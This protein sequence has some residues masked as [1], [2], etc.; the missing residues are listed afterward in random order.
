MALFFIQILQWVAARGTDRL[1]VG[2]L[3]TCG[4]AT[5]AAVV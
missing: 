3:V 1:A 4:I 5:G 2:T